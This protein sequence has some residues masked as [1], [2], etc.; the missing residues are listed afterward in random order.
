M[1]KL[2]NQASYFDQI[3]YIMQTFNFEKV[4]AYMLLTKWKWRGEL[5]TLVEVQ[6]CGRDLLERV[7]AKD[8]NS[9]ST[10]GFTA[11]KFDGGGL[12][13]IFEIESCQVSGE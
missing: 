7:V 2:K 12:Q 10:G 8:I 4:H 3:E 11:C 1:S 6:A 5:P 13:L 9:A